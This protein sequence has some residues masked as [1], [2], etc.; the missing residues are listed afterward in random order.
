MVKT[1]CNLIY[2]YI[3][4]NLLFIKSN[5]IDGKSRMQIEDEAKIYELT[6]MKN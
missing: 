5:N 6:N 1:A 2:I 4:D 3:C